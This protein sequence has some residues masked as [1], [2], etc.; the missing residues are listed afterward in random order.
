[1]SYRGLARYSG[2]GSSATVAKGFQQLKRIGI[3]EALPRLAGSN[4]REPS[5]YR[6]TLD[7][8]KFQAVL[9]E[10]HAR[11]KLE[12]GAE[13][14][15][16]AQ[17]R[18]TT[19]LPEPEPREGGRGIYP[20]TVSL[21][22]VTR[23]QVH[24]LENEACTFSPDP[25]SGA[26]SEDSRAENKGTCES[27]RFNPCNA[28]SELSP[29]KKPQDI[30]PV[31]DS[32]DSGIENKTACTSARFNSCNTNAPAEVTPLVANQE[33]ENPPTRWKA[34]TFTV[35]SE[36]ELAAKIARSKAT[37]AHWDQIAGRA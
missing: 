11:L 9:S 4:F 3:L 30:A 16:L 27:T 13:R 33:R 22:S 20:G 6:F 23:T 26:I 32:Q 18:K 15:L 34:P 37:A 5:T 28:N 31:S 25:K 1:M 14:E 24:A 2:L 17:S 8:E 21:D 7:G 35:L 29:N 12:S 19:A 10:T 36:D